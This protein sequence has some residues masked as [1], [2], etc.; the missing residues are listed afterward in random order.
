MSMIPILSLDT[1]MLNCPVLLHVRSDVPLF[2]SSV[3]NKNM[4][5]TDPEETEDNSRNQ[6]LA[7]HGRIQSDVTGI[8]IAIR[9]YSTQS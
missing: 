7:D 5:N 8:N 4:S 6:R 1:K 3:Q 9:M 2:S